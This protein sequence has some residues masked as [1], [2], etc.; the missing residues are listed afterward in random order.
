M[1]ISN[2]IQRLKPLLID[3][4]KHLTKPTVIQFPVIDTCNSRCQMCRIWE[5]KKSKDITLEQ[6]EVGLSNSLFSEVVSIGF[7]GGEP[8]LREDLKDLVK[9][10]INKLPNLKQISLITNGYKYKQV[11]EQI[12]NIGSEITDKGIF[13]DVMVSLDGYGKVHDAVR[14]RTG[15]FENSQHVINHLKKCSFVNNIRIG[16]TV[17]KENVFYLHDLLEFCIKNDLYIKYRQGVPHKR[18]YTEDLIEPYAL[19]FEEKYEFVEF[20]E[21]LIKNYEKSSLQNHFYRSLIGQIINNSPRVAGCDWKHRG[22]TITAKGELAY[23]A[24]ESDILMEDISKGD[25]NAIYFDNKNHLNDI[26]KNKCD[27]CHH[28]YV[29]MPSPQQYRKIFIEN[30]EYRFKLKEKIKKI[31]L[32]TTLN[33]FRNVSNYNKTLKEYRNIQLDSVVPNESIVKSILI[34]GW[35]GTE[36]LGDKAIIGGIINSIKNKFGEN[37][38]I[39]V[40]SLYPYVTE[41]TKR[42][43]P[44]FKNCKI[45]TI[46]QAIQKANQMDFVMF[47]GG[48]LMAIDSIAPM[49]I[50]FENAKKGKA[51]TIIAGCGVGP[52]GDE[53]YNN[54]IKRILELSDYRIYRDIKSKQNAIDLG[55]DAEED[56]VSEDPAF[57]WLKSVRDNNT[58]L[59]SERFSYNAD[60]KVLLL[61]LRDFPWKE[62][63]QHLSEKESVLIK[64]NYEKVITETLRCL[65]ESDESLIIKP[66]PMCT[67]HFGSDDRWFY[68]N[69]FRD[70]GIPLKNL[71][72][73]LC[74]REMEPIVYCNE[75]IHADALLAMR[76]HSFVFGLAL[77]TPSL[78]LDYTLGKGKVLSLAEK[79][80]SSTVSLS[81]IKTEHLLNEIQLLLKSK[82]SHRKHDL[83]EK[84][85]FPTEL[86]D[87]LTKLDKNN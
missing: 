50:I 14:G 16:C 3:E 77:G 61:G 51:S 5:N 45:L 9:I 39:Y 33:K 48:P 80:N 72:F 54:S 43:M 70:S 76:F 60:N 63:A 62:Y 38:K 55:V 25:A 87:A 7:N 23:C 8:T 27:T 20:L 78:A 64:E 29:G 67:N 59:N 10:C 28:D 69:L 85:T 2:L 22:A 66:L 74:G 47:G 82:K 58:I 18:L 73:S 21:G 34:C 15:N 81:D 12:E 49:Q 75:F 46:E 26:I 37:I 52:L 40:A 36:T 53:R 44:E 56:V 11:I 13:F 19:T 30:I 83:L 71:D 4:T 1:K 24:V 65:V 6:L 84:I 17:I 32:F 31:P 86:Y 41:M 42:Q 57:T 35:Y 79:F 68:R